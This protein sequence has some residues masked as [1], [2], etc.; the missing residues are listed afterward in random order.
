MKDQ[1]VLNVTLVMVTRIN[2]SVFV[3]MEVSIKPVVIFAQ[4]ASII[5]KFVQTLILVA[6][7]NG[8]TNLMLIF[9][10][11]KSVLMVTPILDLQETSAENVQILINVTHASLITENNPLFVSHVQ[12]D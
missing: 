2:A 10:A 5:A 11:L 9:N 8:V 4:S 12:K 1:F 6:S 7:V 3:Q